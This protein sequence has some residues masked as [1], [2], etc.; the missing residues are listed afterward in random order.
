MKSDEE[1]L[2]TLRSLREAARKADTAATAA[3]NA[4]KSECDRL[5]ALGIEEVQT[6]PNDKGYGYLYL[7]RRYDRFHGPGRS[8]YGPIGTHEIPESERHF[9]E[10][11]RLHA[12]Q[13]ELDKLGGAQSLARAEL[14][15]FLE[16][17]V[18]GEPE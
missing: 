1:V 11:A 7:T 4:L 18:A 13:G 2:A 14:R 9:E 12:M 5:L 3:F 6:R 16:A 10:G 8:A 17:V 15:D